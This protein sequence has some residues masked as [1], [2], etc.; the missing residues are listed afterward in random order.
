MDCM[1]QE[2]QQTVVSRAGLYIRF[3]AIRTEKHQTRYASLKGYIDRKAVVEHARPWKQILMFIGRTQGEQEWQKPK[4]KLK[5]GQKKAWKHL[6]RVA[7]DEYSRAQGVVD[8]ESGDVNNDH[9]EQE[10]SPSPSNDLS[11]ACLGFCFSLL[12]EQ[13]SKNEYSNVLVCGSAVL[14]VRMSGARWGWMGA[15]FRAAIYV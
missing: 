6:W 12:Q 9:P 3:E 14:G 2:C 15:D 7:K 1:V 11:L 10:E 13:Y 8:Q 4:Y 5:K